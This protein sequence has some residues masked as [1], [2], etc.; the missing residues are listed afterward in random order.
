MLRSTKRDPNFGHCTLISI[1]AVLMKNTLKLE[2]L[3]L[4]G[5]KLEG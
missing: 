5:L 2:G 3:K 1:G 4:E